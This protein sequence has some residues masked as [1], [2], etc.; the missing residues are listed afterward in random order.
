MG[1]PVGAGKKGPSEVLMENPV[2]PVAEPNQQLHGLES[3]PKEQTLNWRDRVVVIR[4]FYC[5][6]T[7]GEAFFT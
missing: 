6:P 4:S 2:D 7:P 1:D 5:P 3:T